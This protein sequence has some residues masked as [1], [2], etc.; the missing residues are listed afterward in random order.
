MLGMR[1]SSTDDMQW[2]FY[3][4]QCGLDVDLFLLDDSFSVGDI[5]FIDW[6][7]IRAYALYRSISIKSDDITNVNHILT[8]DED[9]ECKLTA[10]SSALGTPTPCHQGIPISDLSTFDITKSHYTVFVTAEHAILINESSSNIS[11]VT[12]NE[13]AFTFTR[14]KMEMDISITN[15][16][17][18]YGGS[19]IQ[20]EINPKQ[21]VPT[22]PNG[23]VLI[24]ADEALFISDDNMILMDIRFEDTDNTAC[25]LQFTRNDTLHSINC[26]DQLLI[27]PGMTSKPIHDNNYTIYMH[28]NDIILST[29][30]K[31]HYLSR[32]IQTLAVN[33]SSFVYLGEA[34][35]LNVSIM[36]DII[37][38]TTSKLFVTSTDLNI[39]VI[40]DIE[41]SKKGHHS[42]EIESVSTGTSRLCTEGIL[43]HR[44]KSFMIGSTYEITFRSEDTYL[45]Q[46]T[47]QIEIE[48]CDIGYGLLA[49]N[50]DALNVPCTPCALNTINYYPNSKCTDC[51]DVDGIECLGASNLTI[52][53]NYWAHFDPQQ[54]LILA[55]YCPAGFCCSRKDGCVHDVAS[56]NASSSNLCAKHRDASMPLCGGCITGYSEV[57]GTANCSKCTSNHYELLLFPLFIAMVYVLFLAHFN[58]NTETN[59]DTS[60]KELS[61]AKLFAKDDM[62]AIKIAILRPMVYLFQAIS[63]ITIQTGYAFYLQPLIDVFSM[64]FIIAEYGGND[65]L[66]LTTHL[67]A[68]WKL[69]WYLFFPIAMLII[70]LIYYVVYEKLSAFRFKRFKPNFLSALWHSVLI[71][72]GT[73]LDKMFKILACR[74]IDS[75]EIGTVHFYAG[76]HQ[77]YGMEWIISLCVLLLIIVFWIGIWYYLYK[78]EP[79]QRNSTKSMSRNLTQSYK[80]R[81][82]YWEF[83]LITRRISL[84]FII[85]FNYL[86]ESFTQYILLS[87]LIFYLII[88]VK[89]SP[90]KHGRVNYFE[91]FCIVLLIL[92]LTCLGFD[93]QQISPLF[94]AIVLSLVVLI[95]FILFIYFIVILIKTY[96][97]QTHKD[98][99]NAAGNID[100]D[101]MRLSTLRGRMTGSQQDV[102][103]H[104]DIGLPSTAASTLRS[105]ASISKDVNDNKNDNNIQ[106]TE[107]NTG[108]TTCKPVK[109]TP[110][111]VMGTGDTS[112][113]ESKKSN[114]STIDIVYSDDEMEIDD[115]D[116]KWVDKAF[117]DGDDDDDDE[118][119]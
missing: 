14:N 56:P 31:I 77:C 64:Q 50:D 35:H 114:E 15:H 84:A 93:L 45:T 51:S 8:I 117:E 102:F 90:F 6:D 105:R 61:Y 28:S 34:I 29:R 27:P 4:N 87:I 116:L 19:Y 89:Y 98:N 63:I 44:L 22:Q 47:I 7:L 42:C 20:F 69:L 81:F 10:V 119:P 101:E 30:S 1:L 41:Y 58:T 12:V 2:I 97:N 3:S 17:A 39:D 40:I 99:S 85:T 74:R 92:G 60:Q 48:E 55:T 104:M 37:T 36:D 94:V 5:L 112:S 75:D 46:Y 80:Q 91:T 111:K 66:C 76:N 33:M 38:Q 96:H 82:W 113:S 109:S 32:E 11:Y 115:A 88:H 62:E 110:V 83:I 26:S 79:K 103:A 100:W 9:S 57:F 23:T 68:I 18:I 24:T 72:L 95:P 78:M 86:S 16:D 52:D 43:F 54:N 49:P 21:T 71:M 107:T 67:T 118:Q 70:I 59:F 13:R 108:E 73:F 25:R 106:L 65:G 53:F